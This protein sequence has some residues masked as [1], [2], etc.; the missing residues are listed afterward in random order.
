MLL[1]LGKRSPRYVDDKLIALCHALK[2]MTK[3]TGRTAE[4]EERQ[5]I[6]CGGAVN[7]VAAADTQRKPTRSETVKLSMGLALR[8]CI[9]RGD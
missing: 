8:F 9:V 1:T 4:K 5:P 6:P 2:A 7:D 3:A